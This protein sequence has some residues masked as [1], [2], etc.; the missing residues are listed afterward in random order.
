MISLRTVWSRGIPRLPARDNIWVA[1]DRFSTP[2]Y[3]LHW[4]LFIPPGDPLTNRYRITHAIF[5]AHHFI[6]LSNL[7]YLILAP[8]SIPIYYLPFRSPSYREYY[9]FIY[10]LTAIPLNRRPTL[11]LLPYA[12]VTLAL[13]L[14]YPSVPTPNTGT[15]SLL[16]L[17]LSLVGS[18]AFF[19]ALAAEIS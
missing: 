18:P 9:L 10:S 19:S 17:S 16:L 7:A 6:Y 12:F 3:E 13:G 4:P 11:S 1:F 2:R 15:H 14:A 8:P 5:L